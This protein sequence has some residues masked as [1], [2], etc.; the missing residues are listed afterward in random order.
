[1][2]WIINIHETHQKGLTLPPQHTNFHSLS[3]WFYI[4]CVWQHL[5]KKH[6]N[7]LHTENLY[8]GF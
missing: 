1:M 3:G 8:I 4:N 6:F 5:D 7:I 2:S